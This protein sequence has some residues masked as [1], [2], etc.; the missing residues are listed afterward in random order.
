MNPERRLQQ[1]DT[2]FRKVWKKKVIKWINYTRHECLNV[3]TNP[4]TINRI[5]PHCF[6]P[7]ANGTYLNRQKHTILQNHWHLNQLFKLKN[8]RNWIKQVWSVISCIFVH[9]M[10][11]LNLV[12]IYPSSPSSASEHSER[13]CSTLFKN[14]LFFEDAILIRPKILLRGVQDLSQI[15]H[16]KFPS[17]N[18]F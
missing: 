2:S 7:L 6:S 14:P 12:H 5:F 16:K 15:G 13:G 11:K 8:Q 10:K 3:S 17:L 18:W 1:V 9:W 4:I